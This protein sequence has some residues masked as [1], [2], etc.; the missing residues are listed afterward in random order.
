MNEKR[1]AILQSNYIPW[2]GY[3]DL[4]RNV[5]EFI[6]LDEVQ[7]TKND[8]RNRNKI[9]TSNG[10]Q[11]LTI[12]VKQ[13]KLCQPISSIQTVD[14]R[15]ASKHWRS[16]MHSYRRSPYFSTYAH[17]VEDAYRQ[18]AELRSLSAVN[19]LF[20]KLACKAL[21]IA[22]FIRPSTD[23][24][25]EPDRIGRLISL[26]KQASA[27]HYLS[28]PAAKSYLDERAFA[29]ANIAVE[30]ADYTEYPEYNQLFP[31]FEHEVTILD[32][33]FNAGPRAKEYLKHF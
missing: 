25:L 16:L 27:T 6:V 8:W 10:L 14:E 30:W 15:W 18:A 24:V 20:I 11:W 23:Y 29:A 13:E 4:I 12:P 5:D 3:F 31:P 22:T 9:K 32:L 21:E 28:G 33:L 7:F 19:L 2:K 17:A 26:C 1:V